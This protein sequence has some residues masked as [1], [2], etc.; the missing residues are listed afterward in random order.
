MQS[1]IYV[2]LAAQ[3]VMQRQLDTIAN[4]VANMN[5]VGFRAE[6][7]NFDSLVSMNEADGVTFP[8]VGHPAPSMEQG[9]LERTGNSLDIALSGPGWFAIETPQGVAYTRDGRLTIDPYGEVRSV[10]NYPVLDASQA[11]IIVNPDGGELEITKDGQVRQNGQLIGNVGVFELPQNAVAS[12]FENAAFFASAEALPI[13][14]GNATKITQGFVENSNVDPIAQM[15]NL[16]TVQRYFESLN[17]T[18]K[19]SED[20]LNQSVHDI[21]EPQA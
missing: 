12:R 14:P 9:T 1:S 21:G 8:V 10:D 19:D 20:A 18:I 11:P 16:I 2:A 4:N 5:T 13:A 7:V 17:A 15:A 6:S 3:Q